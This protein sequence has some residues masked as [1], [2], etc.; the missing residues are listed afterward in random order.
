MT[1]AEC[2]GLILLVMVGIALALGETP[3]PKARA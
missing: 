1:T 2:V 3:P